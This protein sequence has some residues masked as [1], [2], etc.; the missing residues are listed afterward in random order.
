[1]LTTGNSVLAA[2]LLPMLGNSVILIAKLDVA[3]KYPFIFI[4]INNGHGKTEQN[5]L[6]LIG[7][8]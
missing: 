1:M 6:Y 5:G 2:I 4:F 7:I 3:I 8:T